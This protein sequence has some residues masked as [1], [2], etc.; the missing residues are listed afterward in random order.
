MPSV[1]LLE[2]FGIFFYVGLFTIGGGLVAITLMQEQL[3]DR[4]LISPEDFFNMVAISE[5]TPGPV[6]VNMATFLGFEFYGIPGAILTTFAEVL[7]SIICILVIAKFLGAF[8]E[9]EGVKSV[10]S[11]LR[12]SSTG[13][14]F[15]AALNIFV[16]SMMNIESFSGFSLDIQMFKMLFNW[17]NFLF[18]FPMLVLVL[19]TKIHPVF[20]VAL[21]AVFGI[22]FL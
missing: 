21:G 9:R 15:V 1:S 6:G 4:G 17:K 13:L 8:K 2:L 20:V 18:Y 5:S 14:I 7:P 3:V 16:L 22:I 19:K 12:P 10:F 11:V